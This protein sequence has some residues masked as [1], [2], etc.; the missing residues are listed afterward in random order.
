VAA[1][2]KRLRHGI[3]GGAGG[4]H[5]IHQNYLGSWREALDQV[6]IGAPA[7]AL[8]PASPRNTGVQNHSAQFSAQYGGHCSGDAHP[9]N[10]PNKSLSKDRC[11][12]IATFP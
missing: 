12:R 3:D 2:G 10:T 1:F 4:H 7:Q 9:G 6:A 8:F 11:G 5:V